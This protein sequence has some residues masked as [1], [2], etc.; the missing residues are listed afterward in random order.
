MP[1]K[2]VYHKTYYSLRSQIYYPYK[3]DYDLK[4]RERSSFCRESYDAKT[5]LPLKTNQSSETACQGSIIGMLGCRGFEFFYAEVELSNVQQGVSL[6]TQCVRRRSG[7][8]SWRKEI[9]E[10]R[11]RDRDSLAADTL[12]TLSWCQC[13]RPRASPKCHQTVEAG[14]LDAS[15]LK[16]KVDDREASWRRTSQQE[17]AR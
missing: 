13:R 2:Y 12:C 15:G 14:K 3:I 1:P 5:V 6:S 11:I 7:S 9:I 4:R 17:E 10:M 8:E 16:E